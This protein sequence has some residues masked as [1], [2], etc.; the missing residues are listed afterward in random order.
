[1]SYYIVIN[2]RKN[3]F[4]DW[5]IPYFVC[6]KAFKIGPTKKEQIDILNEYGNPNVYLKVTEL[7]AAGCQPNKHLR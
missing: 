2:W 1:M 3:M 6:S 4:N 7:K 5:L